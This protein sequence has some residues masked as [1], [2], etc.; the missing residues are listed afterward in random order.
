MEIKGGRAMKANELTIGQKYIWKRNSEISHEVTYLGCDDS[1]FFSMYEFE[2]IDNDAEKHTLLSAYHIETGIQQYKQS[3]FPVKR[4]DLCIGEL[5]KFKD[6]NSV[7]TY[8]GN[9]SYD[10]QDYFIYKNGNE[11]IIERIQDIDKQTIYLVER[12]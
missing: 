11:P 6:Y 5:F 3:L 9:Y 10:R 4:A 2:Y 7:Y 8:M 12:V 1:G